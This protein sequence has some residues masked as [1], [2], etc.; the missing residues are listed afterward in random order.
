MLRKIKYSKIAIVIFLTVLIWV[1]ADLA[2]DETVSVPGAMITVAESSDD[3]LWISFGGKASTSIDNIVL[4]GP[5]S[6][7]AEIKRELNDSSLELK[8]SLYPDWQGITTAGSHTINVLDF[9]KKSA[10]LRELSGLTA[11]TC[12][13]NT[14]TVDVAK[15]V[16]RPLTVQCIDESGNELKMYESIE[17]LKVNM[18]APEDW[19]NDKLIAKVRLTRSEIEQ[20]REEPEEPIEK[21]PYVELAAEQIRESATAVTIKLAPEEDPLTVQRIE[22]ATLVIAM[23][24]TLLAKYYVDVTNLPSVLNS[25]AVRA[26][27]DAKR[28]YEDQ[29]LPHMTLYIFD[30]DTEKG[31]EVQRKKVHYNFPPE[32][33]RTGTIELNQEPATAEFKLIPR[34]SAESE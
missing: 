5:A 28:A 18:L 33:V 21:K 9:I 11:E 26:T 22:D 15:L 6:K 13:P 14:L 30:S 2:L 23:S 31:Q 17:P 32:N 8:F 7:I 27:T 20:A 1:W 16:V 3:N 25:I 24:P 10:E 19:G 34:P 29:L 12:E 4:K